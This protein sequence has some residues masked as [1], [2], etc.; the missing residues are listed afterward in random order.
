[1]PPFSNL[2][3][4]LATPQLAKTSAA[5]TWPPAVVN[6]AAPD[7]QTGEAP[8]SHLR[9]PITDDR[10]L[11]TLLYIER[12]L[13]EDLRLRSLCERV[14]LSAFHFHRIVMEA[15]GEPL[16]RYVTKRR[17]LYAADR[18]LNGVPFQDVG[19]LIGYQTSSSFST[20]FR[21]HFHM[22]PSAFL[23]SAENAAKLHK[24]P[25]LGS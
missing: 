12:N 25:P 20:V 19:K 4:S 18:I 1:M 23:V 13:H 3:S 17:M 21:R 5:A 24:D 11:D 16:H 2:R 14:H 9:Q 15:L 10:I 22:T 8:L 6:D 7:E